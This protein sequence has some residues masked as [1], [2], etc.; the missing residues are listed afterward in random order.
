ML[1]PMESP[2]EWMM[3]NLTRPG[4]LLVFCQGE[5]EGWWEGW[6]SYYPSRSLRS[7]F[8]CPAR[9]PRAIQIETTEEGD[10]SVAEWRHL[11]VLLQLRSNLWFDVLISQNVFK[12]LVNFLL[13]LRMFRQVIQTPC[14]H[15][16]TKKCL[17]DTKLVRTTTGY[18]RGMQAYWPLN[19]GL[20]NLRILKKMKMMK[21][22]NIYSTTNRPQ[23]SL[24]IFVWKE[25]R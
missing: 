22:R 1:S 24:P 13:D 5:R 15:Y 6:P 12:F 4:R 8:S 19:T 3:I 11:I 2:V 10:E 20:T 17:V 21:G 14:H 16:K 18:P 25:R 9:P 7:R 23:V